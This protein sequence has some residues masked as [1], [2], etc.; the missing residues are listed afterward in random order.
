MRNRLYPLAGAAVC[1]V[2]G[3]SKTWKK[4]LMEYLFKYITQFFKL[5]RGIK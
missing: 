1:M 5:H 4:S 2:Y 3:A